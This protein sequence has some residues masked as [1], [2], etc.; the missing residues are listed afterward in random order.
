MHNNKRLNFISL[1]SGTGKKENCLTC[2]TQL[3]EEVLVIAIRQ[4]KG[5]SDTQIR[6]EEVKLFSYDIIF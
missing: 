1:R 4:E 6:K 3:L 5:T 2:P